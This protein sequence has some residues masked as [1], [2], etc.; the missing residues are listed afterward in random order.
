MDDP[1]IGIIRESGT[2]WPEQDLLGRPYSKPPQTTRSIGN[3]HFVVIPMSMS[4][5]A[6]QEALAGLRGS[7]VAQARTNRRGAVIP[8]EQSESNS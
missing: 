7:N 2:Q 4:E 3:G 6:I 8:D 5:E 1:R